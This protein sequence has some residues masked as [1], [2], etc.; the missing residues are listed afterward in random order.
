[1]PFTSSSEWLEGHDANM[2]GMT[3]WECPYDEDTREAVQWLSGW[4]AADFD[5]RVEMMEAAYGQNTCAH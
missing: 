1:M 5:D 3:R 4:D 2:D